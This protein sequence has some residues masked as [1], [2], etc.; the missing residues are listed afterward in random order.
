MSDA[1]LEIYPTPKTIRIGTAA[2]FVKPSTGYSF[3]RTQRRLSLLVDELV[4]NGEPPKS[5]V[6]NSSGWKLLL[7]SVL[8][9]VLESNRHPADQVF[10]DIFK[11]NPA[12]RVLRFL[13]EKTSIGEDLR[14]M[15]TVPIRP[16]LV[17]G[18]REISKKVFD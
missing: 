1:P 15:S 17:A 2:G 12:T 4:R 14:L 8:L 6:L 18:F 11:H 10:T 16:F 3:M 9:N 5:K 7:D 13:D